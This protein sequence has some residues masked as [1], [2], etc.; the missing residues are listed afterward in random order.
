M[1]RAGVNK[2]FDVNNET[3]DIYLNS[4]IATTAKTVGIGAVIEYV[5]LGW[6]AQGIAGSIG[7]HIDTSKGIIVRI[8]KQTWC[9]LGIE[10]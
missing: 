2:V 10:Y 8:N 9:K 6:L 3:I 7:D 5:G 1:L 4:Y